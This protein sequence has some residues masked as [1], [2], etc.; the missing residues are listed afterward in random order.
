MEPKYDLRF[1]SVMKDTQKAHH[2][3]FGFRQDPYRVPGRMMF[4][5]SPD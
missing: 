3:T 1:V 4:E 5:M 2:L